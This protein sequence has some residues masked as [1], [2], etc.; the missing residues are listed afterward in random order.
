MAVF[1]FMPVILTH[2][3]IYMY[4]YLH[5]FLGHLFYGVFKVLADL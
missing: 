1:M 2:F 3:V 5:I 4:I